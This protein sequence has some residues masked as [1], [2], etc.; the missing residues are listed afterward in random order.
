MR[1]ERIQLNGH[2]SPEQRLD[3]L[4]PDRSNRLATGMY[5]FGTQRLGP[6]PL[7][8]PSQH[9]GTGPS[10]SHHKQ[11]NNSLDPVPEDSSLGRK[12]SL[13]S[14]QAQFQKDQ[15]RAARRRSEVGGSIRRMSVEMAEQDMR[16]SP[17]FD[18][19]SSV[20]LSPR[21][22]PGRLLSRE[23]LEP[24][25][26]T[27]VARPGRAL[28]EARVTLERERQRV[29]RNKTRPDWVIDLDDMEVGIKEWTRPT[30]SRVIL[31]LG[32]QP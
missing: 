16:R 25:S 23:L 12:R 4:I 13:R 3:H 9:A 21:S 28:S 11:R 31:M 10:P 1:P 17:L 22:K 14:Q 27:P 7:A 20:L 24:P 6:S 18:S 30:K 15:A 26:P 32:G 29:E 8:G 19:N 2:L 5:E